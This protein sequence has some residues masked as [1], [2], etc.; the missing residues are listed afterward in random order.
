MGSYLWTAI[1]RNLHIAL[2][3]G[4]SN[5]LVFLVE[6]FPLLLFGFLLLHSKWERIVPHSEMEIL[7]TVWRVYIRRPILLPII[8][9]LLTKLPEKLLPSNHF[10]WHQ[11]RIRIDRNFLEFTRTF[12]GQIFTTLF[13]CKDSETYFILFILK[14]CFFLNYII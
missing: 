3:S 13:Q 4:T 11:F 8:V 9:R 5:F 2:E 12:I 14:I 7:A 6:V 10:E 1:A